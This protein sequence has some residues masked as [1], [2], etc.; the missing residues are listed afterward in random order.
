MQLTLEGRVAA[1]GIFKLV[2]GLLSTQAEKQDAS[3]FSN[4]CFVYIRCL[5]SLGR[6]LQINDPARNIVVTFCQFTKP[7]Y[8]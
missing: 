4:C 7:I 3:N 5:M 1:F 2:E 8:S 6:L